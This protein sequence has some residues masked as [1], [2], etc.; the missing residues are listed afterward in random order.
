MANNQS[1]GMSPIEL[2]SG[3]FV[4]EQKN[5]RSIK[6]VFLWYPRIK[7]YCLSIFNKVLSLVYFVSVDFLE[8][9][10]NMLGVFK[11]CYLNW[12]PIWCPVVNNEIEC[13]KG[14]LY[15]YDTA[16]YCFT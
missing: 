8:E 16:A 3:F 10:C 13:K 4:K 9:G 7:I 6:S 1:H 11:S 14:E 15:Y 2:P 12:I 5:E